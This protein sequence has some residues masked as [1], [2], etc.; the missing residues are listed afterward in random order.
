MLM[1]TTDLTL[2]GPAEMSRR[3][4]ISIKALRVYEQQGLVKPRRSRR[5]WR[6]YTP[7]DRN[8]LARA[9]DFKAM[10]FC[11]S[12]IATL[13]DAG[14]DAVAAAL[15]G[16]EARLMERRVGLDDALDALRDARRRLGA[17]VLR[18]AA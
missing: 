4:G 8:R 15:A 13:L 7:E 6:I 12:Q 11:L 5:G 18:L 17:P 3:L 14:P 10:G 16:Q 2:A 1:R 9:L